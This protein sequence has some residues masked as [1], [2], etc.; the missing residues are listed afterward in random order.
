MITIDS[1]QAF[2]EIDALLLRMHESAPFLE[3]VGDREVAEVQKR[4][5][6]TK[7]DPLGNAWAPWAPF[8]RSEREHKGNADLGLL[9]DEGDLLL[10]IDKA[11]FGETV[12][13]GSNLDYAKDLQEGTDK[14]PAREFLGWAPGSGPIYENLYKRYI[15]T[16]VI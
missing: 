3:A 12:E 13:I 7:L 6:D 10:S 2:A 15:E 9:L 1:A 11:M 8:T 5:R 4:I 16:G 14:M